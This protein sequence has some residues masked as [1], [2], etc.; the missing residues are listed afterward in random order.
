M[1]H[2]GVA[3]GRRRASKL[4]ARQV[5]HGIFIAAA[6]RAP[7]QETWE[8]SSSDHAS[9][10][11]SGGLSSKFPQNKEREGMSPRTMV[12]GV[13]RPWGLRGGALHSLKS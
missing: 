3:V 1:P 13:W 2:R 6:R 12:A 10:A 8:H 4:T 7:L 5:D 11:D 9:S